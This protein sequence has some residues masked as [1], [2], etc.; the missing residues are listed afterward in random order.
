MNSKQY[1]LIS[2]MKSRVTKARK[3]YARLS[4]LNEEPENQFHWDEM[5]VAEGLLSGLEQGLNV[6]RAFAAEMKGKS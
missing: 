1:L 6:L 3:N 4:R 2:R 5:K